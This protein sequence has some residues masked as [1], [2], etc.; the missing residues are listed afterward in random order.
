MIQIQSSIAQSNTASLSGGIAYIQNAVKFD[1]FASEFRDFYAPVSMFM[2]S[3]AQNLQLK[4]T[5]TTI[6]CD[7]LYDNDA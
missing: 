6:I 4:V 1:I 2:Y 7:S 5:R 3:I